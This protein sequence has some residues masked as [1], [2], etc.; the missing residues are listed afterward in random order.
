MSGS[1][2]DHGDT[3][4]ILTALGTL[5]DGQRAVIA[6]LGQLI[7]TVG[8]LTT[9]QG[10]LIAT[11]GQLTATVGQLIASHE[12]LEARVE[13]LEAA[14]IATRTDLMGRMDRLQDSLTLIR[15]DVSVNMG[16]ASAMQRANDNTRELVRQQG[17]QMNVMWRQLKN[18]EARVRDITGDP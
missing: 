18:L 3:A 9:S 7:A 16:A 14:H 1:G 6:E 11:V 15:D 12:Q 17:E 2:P 10:Q 8:Q 5:Q 13:T 4:T